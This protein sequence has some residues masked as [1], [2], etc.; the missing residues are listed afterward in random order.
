[1]RTWQAF[2][3]H[4]GIAT[5]QVAVGMPFTKNQAANSAI[6]LGAQMGMMFLQGWVAKKNSETDPQGNPIRKFD[7]NILDDIKKREASGGN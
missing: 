3:A 4:A 5:A 1:M 6:T 7:P 2:L